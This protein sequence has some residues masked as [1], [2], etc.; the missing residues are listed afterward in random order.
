ML[1]NIDVFGNTVPTMRFMGGREFDELIKKL[2]ITT[3]NRPS[4]T[5]DLLKKYEFTS[6][7]IFLQ[8]KSKEI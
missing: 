3:I 4:I 8:N 1:C 6:F 7:E 2:K 5:K